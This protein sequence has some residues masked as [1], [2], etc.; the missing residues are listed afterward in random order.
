[1]CSS[2]GRYPL[3]MHILARPFLRPTLQTAICHST[4]RLLLM[5]FSLLILP[6]LF[7]ILP[8]LRIMGGN[9]PSAP[10]HLTA[11]ARLTSCLFVDWLRRLQRSQN[12]YTFRDSSS[13]DRSLRAGMIDILDVPVNTGNHWTCIR[14]NI[15]NCTYSYMDS[16]RPSAAPPQDMLLLLQWYLT[17]VLQSYTFSTFTELPFSMPRQRDTH[18]CGVAILSTLAFSHLHYLPWEPSTAYAERMEWFLRLST[19]LLDDSEEWLIVDSVSNII[20]RCSPFIDPLPY[21]IPRTQSLK[22]MI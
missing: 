12:T 5:C 20:F 8:L 15:Q 18:S 13:L 9:T 21:R 14:I 1:M 3:L 16:L 2:I 19:G 6:L 10:P 7:P 4:H 11:A 22:C 17:T